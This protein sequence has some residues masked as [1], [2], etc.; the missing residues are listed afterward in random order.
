MAFNENTRVKIPAILYLTR[1]GYEYVSLKNANWD[2]D[3]NIFTEI[4]VNSIKRINQSQNNLKPTVKFID[5]HY[6]TN[7]N[8]DGVAAERGISGIQG[9]YKN[10]DTKKLIADAVFNTVYSNGLWNGILF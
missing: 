2:E 5:D 1:L 10:I 7:A 4:F 9:N 3:T 8:F 6:E